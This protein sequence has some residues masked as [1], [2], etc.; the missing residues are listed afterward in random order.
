MVDTE[1]SHP[2]LLEELARLDP[3]ARHTRAAILRRV[4]QTFAEV[5]DG[6]T[7]SHT[8]SRYSPT[9]STRR[10]GCTMEVSV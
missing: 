6:K 5:P 3:H 10:Y 9:C 4:S 8:C 2:T 1:T 7:G